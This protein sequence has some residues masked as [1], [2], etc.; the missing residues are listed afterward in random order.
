MTSPS[1]IAGVFDRAA[2]SYDNIGV[3]WFQP[4]ADGLV[5]ELAVRPGERVLDIACGRGAA[6][7]PLAR[8]AGPTGRAL[9]IDLSPRMVQRT[10]A[11]AAELPWV[12]V[13]VA[14][15]REPGLAPS[16]YDVV[17]SSLVLFFLPEPAAVVRT[18]A[19]LLVDG[20]RLGVTTFGTQ[21]ERWQRVDALFR[22]YLPADLLDARTSGAQGPFSS[23]EG[24][25]SLLRAAGL[26]DVRTVHRVVTAAF[27]D[28]QQLLEFSWSHGQRAMWEAVPAEVHDTLRRQIGELVAAYLDGAGG[29]T[30]DQQVR[31]TLA[32][33]V[34]AAV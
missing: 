32:R 31:H 25:A 9:G 20:G 28:T 15:A 18:W 13:R 11:D 22:P 29:F 6:L 30:F 5:A 12:E 7:L 2:D 16:S 14:D 34:Q 33:R 3:P 19:D 24:M 17:A 1:G 10:A 27:R 23:D 26:G 8:A 21:D 4:I